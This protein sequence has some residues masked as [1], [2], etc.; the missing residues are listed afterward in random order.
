MK[1]RFNMIFGAVFMCM[2]IISQVLAVTY[3][4]NKNDN[5][6][7]DNVSTLDKIYT[8]DDVDRVLE[9][10]NGNNDLTQQELEVYD[11]DNNGV[12]NSIDASIML[13]YSK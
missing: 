12:I 10:Y 6:I 5:I 11:L 8:Q 1:K 9:I 13:L 3:A 7:K 4:P 2:A